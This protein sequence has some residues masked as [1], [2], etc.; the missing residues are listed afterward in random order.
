MVVVVG[1][2]DGELVVWGGAVDRGPEDEWQE[3]EMQEG[4]GKYSKRVKRIH[5]RRLDWQRWGEWGGG[6]GYEG[7]TNGQGNGARETDGGR[8][9]KDTVKWAGE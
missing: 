9:Q 6:G 2:A 1:E 5:V 8:R 4:G 7:D 3:G